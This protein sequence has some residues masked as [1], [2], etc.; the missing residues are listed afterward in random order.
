MSDE[1]DTSQDQDTLDALGGDE[2]VPSSE[3]EPEET[4]DFSDGT[5]LTLANLEELKSWHDRN[6]N[7][8]T[9]NQERS[10]EL[11][12]GEGALKDH[13]KQTQERLNRR[14]QKLRKAEL[15]LN[16]RGN[17]QAAETYQKKYETWQEDQNA[18]IDL[19]R[20]FSDYDPEVLKDFHKGFNMENATDYRML[21]FLAW[22]GSQLE[23]RIQEARAE[24]VSGMEKKRGLPPRGMVGTMPEEFHTVDEAHAGG[25]RKLL[26]LKEG[27]K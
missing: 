27:G 8:I 6:Q 9:K 17:Q 11:G 3:E 15:D 22:K 20:E 4:F 23:N 26:G 10:E 19:K 24:V 18:V 7:W 25:L 16:N 13:T 5:K 14:E 12:K 21:V 1:I 2:T